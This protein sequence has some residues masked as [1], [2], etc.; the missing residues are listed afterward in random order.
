MWLIG[1]R[2]EDRVDA[3][4][5]RLRMDHFRIHRLDSLVTNLVCSFCFSHQSA[6]REFPCFIVVVVCYSHQVYAHRL[7]IVSGLA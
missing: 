5:I 6:T 7:V 4:D 3:S 2:I 1:D